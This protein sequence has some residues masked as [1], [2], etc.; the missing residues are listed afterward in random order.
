MG[1][2]TP[3]ILVLLALV[4]SLVWSAVAQESPPA[5][6]AA[7]EPPTDGPVG[8]PERLMIKVEGA[9]MPGT[10]FDHVIH[11]T[12]ECKSCHHLGRTDQKCTECHL[13]KTTGEVAGAQLAFH[14]NCYKCHV[15]GGASNDKAITCVDCHKE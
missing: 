8:V 4:A 7:E 1:T 3:G 11:D 13:A 14:E 12:G 2:R 6:P 5:P 15:E 10:W 9:G